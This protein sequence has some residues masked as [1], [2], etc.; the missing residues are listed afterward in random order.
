MVAAIGGT[1]GGSPRDC[2]AAI[3]KLA[4]WIAIFVFLSYPLA[5]A[6]QSSGL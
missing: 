4:N 2:A 6:Q 5:P 3:Q 1:F